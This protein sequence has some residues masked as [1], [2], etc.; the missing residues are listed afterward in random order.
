MNKVKEI[1]FSGLSGSYIKNNIKHKFNLKQSNLV[2]EVIGVDNTY[3]LD[4]Y[5]NLT[6]KYHKIKTID[7]VQDV[8][9]DK[10]S[11]DSEIILDAKKIFNIKSVIRGNGVDIYPYIRIGEVA[12]VVIDKMSGGLIR[13]KN[14]KTNNN[15]RAVIKAAD[16]LIVQNQ[17]NDKIIRISS[18]KNMT[19]SDSELDEKILISAEKADLTFDK[20]FD[21]LT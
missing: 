4:F 1:S 2:L 11:E 15:P 14:S 8:F 19:L 3:Q 6:H 20:E 5:K 12:R 18:A 13:I 7:E 9:I 16:K 10:I 21:I 17:H